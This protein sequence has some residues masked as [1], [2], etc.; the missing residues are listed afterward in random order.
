MFDYMDD[1]LGEEAGDQMRSR[2]N[3]VLGYS[4][5]DELSAGAFGEPGVVRS[6]RGN[7]YVYELGDQNG[8]KALD[9]DLRY[10]TG[11]FGYMDPGKR[12]RLRGRI[13]DMS[14]NL[15]TGTLMPWNNERPLRRVKDAYYGIN[16][17]LD[18]YGGSSGM[19]GVGYSR[20]GIRR[21]SRGSGYRDDEFYSPL[22]PASRER[23][24]GGGYYGGGYNGGGYNG[25]RY[26][27]SRGAVR[28][29]YG[30]TL[31]GIAGDVQRGY[32]SRGLRTPS[33]AAIERRIARMNNIENRNLIYAGE[34]LRVR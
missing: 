27:S 23:Y 22:L 4:G 16:R 12:D 29:R 34:I 6:R 30:D 18:E 11:S 17:E 5:P 1:Y 13:R 21:S 9:D 26:A 33:S 7:P 28:V 19:L 25:S 15:K 32:R 3:E 8:L 31:S 2:L 14:G 24:H 20:G 10:G